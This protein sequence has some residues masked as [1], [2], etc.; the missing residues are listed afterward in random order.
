L[1]NDEET[2]CFATP[3]QRAGGDD[4]EAAQIVNRQYRLSFFVDDLRVDDA[5]FVAALAGWL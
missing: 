4:L 1:T 5:A 3:T 2:G